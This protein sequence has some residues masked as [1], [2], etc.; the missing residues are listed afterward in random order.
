MRFEHEKKTKQT[1]KLDKQFLVLYLIS[2]N[3]NIIFVLPLFLLFL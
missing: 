1:F 3:F 2:T